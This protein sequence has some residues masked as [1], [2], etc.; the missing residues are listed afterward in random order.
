MNKD[1][2]CPHANKKEH[3]R[4]T[5]LHKETQKVSDT[6]RESSPDRKRERAGEREQEEEGQKEMKRMSNRDRDLKSKIE[7]ENP[8]RGK[9]IK[10]KRK[11]ARA[12]SREGDSVCV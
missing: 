4:A 12:G 7:T 9:G 2:S 6:E 5:E 10:G 3:N 8:D 1:R 11:G